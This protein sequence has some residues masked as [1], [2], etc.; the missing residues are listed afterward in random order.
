MQDKKIFVSNLFLKI[1]SKLLRRDCF[2]NKYLD[3]FINEID[4]WL[5]YVIKNKI[6]QCNLNEDK[7][8]FQLSDLSSRISKQ[9]REICVLQGEQEFLSGKTR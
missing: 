6:E 5:F 7:I 2:Y 9:E 3:K 1:I 8:I 4:S